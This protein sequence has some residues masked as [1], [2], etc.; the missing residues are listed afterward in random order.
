MRTTH[1]KS[2]CYLSIIA[3][4]L[5]LPGGC[6]SY[7]APGGAAKMSVFTEQAGIQGEVIEIVDDRGKVVKIFGRN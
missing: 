1:L 2:V 3:F 6:S 5:V 4:C 7:T